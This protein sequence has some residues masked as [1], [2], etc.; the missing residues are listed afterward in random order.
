MLNEQNVGKR[1]KMII[2]AM[3]PSPFDMEESHD[4]NSCL[5]ID[6]K[7]YAYEE[8]KLTSINKKISSELLTTLK[9]QKNPGKIADHISAQLNISIF[10]KQKLL[11]IIDLKNRLEKFTNT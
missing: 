4:Q 10:E 6:E 9:E 7:I 3:Y 11:E 1:I 2:A 5:I 8:E